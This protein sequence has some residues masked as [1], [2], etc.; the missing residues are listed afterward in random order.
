MNLK[1]LIIAIV[2][3]TGACSES[4]GP[5]EKRPLAQMNPT[6]YVF[7]RP[8]A[9][10]RKDALTAFNDFEQARA[11]SSQISLSS[12]PVIVNTREDMTSEADSIFADPVNAKDFYI[13]SLDMPINP[14]NP[15]YYSAGKPLEYFAD[16]HIHFEPV[17]GKNTKVT[18][19]AQRARV[20]NGSGCCSPHGSVAIYQDVE[21]TTVEEYRFLEWIGR[22]TG[23]KNMPPITLPR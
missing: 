6:S 9:D 22:I 18:V 21:P 4:P 20:V 13:T 12:F 23:T 11:F 17:D 1:A 14:P 19:I 7:A 5:L 8:L 15:V 2:G 10:L 16:F 3:L